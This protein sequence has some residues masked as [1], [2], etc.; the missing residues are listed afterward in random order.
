[1]TTSRVHAR[2]SRMAWSARAAAWA[3]G[4]AL[5]LTAVLV[6]ATTA[7]AQQNQ[8]CSASL[9][10]DAHYCKGGPAACDPSA[11]ADGMPV[12]ISVEIQNESSFAVPPV[13]P[14]NPPGGV[15]QAGSFMKVYYSCSAAT[16][17]AGTELA[18]RF[19]FNGVLSIIPGASFVD[20]GNGYSGTLNFTADIPFAR[21]DTT[22]LEA[23]RLDMT[24]KQPPAAPFEQV[25]ARAG[26]PSPP[27]SDDS[28][29]FFE[30]TDVPTC[31]PNLLGGGQGTTAGLFGGPP[32]PPCGNN[33]RITFPTATKPGTVS[34][35]LRTAGKLS[36]LMTGKDASLTIANSG[37]TCFAATVL[38]TDP[39][40]KDTP[41][42]C[43]YSNPS[44]QN[45]IYKISC[46]QRASNGGQI[47]VRVLA[48]GDTSNC[49]LAGMTT[50]VSVG[51]KTLTQ[52][53]T[54]RSTPNGWK[55][56]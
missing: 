22:V 42:L 28:D 44:V 25:F 19:Q 47:Q 4:S 55:F 5:A 53:G 12:E 49:N 54:W 7:S 32:P 51:G 2:R 16:C 24:A 56:P 20:D 50:T 27:G 38:S 35:A 13:G 43:N 37:G 3:A 41:N 30:I 21:G 40:W 11:F 45:G 9:N 10:V 15:I 29:N 52:S 26:Q 23:V 6:A 34:V 18:G 14:P 31:L 36:D 17:A 1:M 8:S 39:G 46:Q 48:R 33:A